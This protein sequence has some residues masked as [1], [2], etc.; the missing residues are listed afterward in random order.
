M[1][2]KQNFVKK[3]EWTFTHLVQKF[4]VSE[5]A[6]ELKLDPY[7]LIILFNIARYLDMP[8]KKCFG[9]QTT[10][11]F[12]CHMSRNEFQRRSVKLQKLNLIQRYLKGKLYHY[13]LGEELTNISE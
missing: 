2:D 4:M 7:D 9:K 13:E 12:D 1:D 11:S 6:H 8:F 10:L 5:K 3:Q